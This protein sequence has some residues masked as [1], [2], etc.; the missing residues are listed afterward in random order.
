MAVEDRSNKYLI[1]GAGPGGLVTARAFM[2]YDV[3]FEMVERHSAI[4]GIWDKDNP[5]S[6]VYSSCHF[7]SSRDYGAFIGFPMPRSYPMY[8][9]WWQIR[10]YIRSFAAHYGIDEKVELNKNVVDVVCVETE[11]GKRW[12]ITFDSGEQR[13]YRGVVSA[14]GGQWKGVIP[15][16]EGTENFRGEIIHS[17]QYADPKYLEGKTVLVVG[18]GNSGVDIAADASQRADRA[19]LSTRRG[20]WYLPKL[21]FGRPVGDLLQGFI[22][23]E[24]LPPILRG[25]TPPEIIQLVL[26]SVV[27]D[28]TNYGLPAPDHEL[29]QTHPITNFEVIHGL[30][31]GTLEYRPK[32]ER[33]TENGVLFSDGQEEQIDLVVL[34]TGFDLHIPW[35]NEEIVPRVDEVPQFHLG[36]LAP[37]HEGMYAAGT[38]HFAGNT[39]PVFD[40]LV[41]VVA[42]EVAATINEEDLSKFKEIREEYDPSFKDEDTFLDLRRN[43]NHVDVVKM[44]EYFEV[45]ESKYGIPIPSFS[46][47]DF[48]AEL[49]EQKEVQMA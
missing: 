22:P 16:F 5:G 28:V 49:E 41:Q 47:P 20:Y 31:H 19:F 44:A 40:Q 39:F 4:G 14:S 27:G 26:E 13:I 43:A 42:A 46:K 17:S 48:Y 15:E 9:K 36:S 32:I 29:G 1:V 35:V 7:I 37:G 12:K 34:A 45:L 23:D 38:F 30:A 3:P 33:F 11:T 21:A 6:P 24:E 25:K 18:A 10:D 2:K 8:P